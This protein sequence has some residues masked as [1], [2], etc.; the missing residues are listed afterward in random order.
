MKVLGVDPGISG[1]I[2]LV[3][4]VSGDVMQTW[5]MPLVDVTRPNGKKKRRLDAQGLYRIIRE[6]RP[7][8]A[9]V[10][11]VHASPGMGVV[12]AFSFGHG[13]GVIDAVI[14]VAKVPMQRVSPNW[15]KQRM[16]V[17]RDKAETQEAATRI[18]GTDKYWP[19]R[20]H[21]GLAE[22]ALIA[23]W[24]A[25]EGKAKIEPLPKVARPIKPRSAPRKMVL[26]PR[27]PKVEAAE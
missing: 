21:N 24:G 25:R 8:R 9:Y 13:A 22:A 4:S 23:L 7:E 18:F 26:T 15:W 10:E 3:D 14:D 1:G 11:L 17:T 12:S 2:A 5:L 6:A 19:L 16:G 27:I 20:K